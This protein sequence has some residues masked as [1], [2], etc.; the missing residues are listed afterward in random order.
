M[1]RFH[2]S[3]PTMTSPGYRRS[4]I[5]RNSLRELTAPRKRGFYQ[6]VIV[7]FC[8][9]C[10]FFIT[11]QPVSAQDQPPQGG[12]TYV[13]QAGDTL[14]LIALKFGTSVDD[15]LKVN[16]LVNPDFLSPGDELVIPGLEGVQGKLTTENLALGETLRSL[17]VRHQITVEQITKLNHLTSPSEAFAGASLILPDPGE[18]AQPEGRYLMGEGQSLLELAVSKNQNPWLLA[19]L[20]QLQGSWEAL[21]NEAIF[22][23]PSGE[24]SNGQE[25]AGVSLISPLIQTLE[26]DPLPL[27]QG[28]TTVI[29]V[30]APQLSEIS[31]TLAGSELHFFPNGENQ[32]AALQGIHAMA[33]PGLVPIV[34]QGTAKDGQ[35]FSFEQMMVLQLAGYST[36]R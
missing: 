4:R 35:R 30:K 9:S 11:T 32:W 20:N 29:K 31:G 36:L 18:N 23:P 13:V 15:I 22:A 14:Y 7:V 1:S 12:P 26:V 3:R 16:T 19:E 5:W 33:D 2:Q 27:T 21:P 17:S 24:E 8:L 10:L 34:L 6:Q 25:E 28:F